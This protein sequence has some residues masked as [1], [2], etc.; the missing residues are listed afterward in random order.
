MKLEPPSPFKAANHNQRL[1]GTD[2]LARLYDSYGRSIYLFALKL[3]TNPQEAE[4]LTQEVFLTFWQKNLYDHERGTVKQ[5]LMTMTYSRAIDRLRRRSAFGRALQRLGAME[6]Q[7]T[8][9]HGLEIAMA[10]EHRVALHQA[11]EQL[12]FLQ[13]QCLQLYYFKGMNQNE[14]AQHLKVPLSTIKTRCRDALI[15]LKKLMHEVHP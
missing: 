11:M 14:I 9:E 7:H 15:H 8:L 4:E 3:L 1:S 13:R 2:Y 6:L 12:S 10:E 5:L